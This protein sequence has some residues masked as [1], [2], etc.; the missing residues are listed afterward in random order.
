MIIRLVRFGD[1]LYK[2]VK[3]I[4]RG[5]FIPFRNRRHVISVEFHDGVEI[6]EECAFE[7]CFRLKGPISLLGVKIIKARAFD[8]CSVTGV[9]FGDQLETIE[10]QA[11]SFNC[12]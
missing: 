11:F 4:P 9:K 3:I 10:E 5:A 7:G 6:I 1:E 8:N 12:S 2:S